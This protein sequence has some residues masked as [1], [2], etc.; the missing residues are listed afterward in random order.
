M[1][2]KNRLDDRPMAIPP[3]AIHLFGPLRVTVRGAPFPRVRTRSVEWLLAL[4]ALRHGRPV[5]RAWLAGTL[6][7]ESG[8][9]RSLQNLRDDLMRLR[10]ALGPEGE[11]IQAPGRDLLTLDLCGA[12][13]DVR[14]FD[15]GVQAGDEASLHEAVTVYT[16]PLLQVCVEEWVLW[17]THLS[18]SVTRVGPDAA[19]AGKPPPAT[20]ATASPA[21]PM[22]ARTNRYHPRC[23]MIA[24]FHR[25]LARGSAQRTLTGCS[26]TAP[27]R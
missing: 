5:R 17:V 9:S 2:W 8:E 3:L 14:R 21:L 10:Q 25:S 27:Y 26:T 1:R 19:R 22:T 12:A 6:W 24:P 20:P 18:C 13:V 23:L 11:R 16:G 15:A 7:P 4:L